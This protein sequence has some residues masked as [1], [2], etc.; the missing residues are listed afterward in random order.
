MD[1]TNSSKTEERLVE[2]IKEKLKR[3]MDQRLFKHSLGTMR[4][5]LGLLKRHFPMITSTYRESIEEK[6]LVLKISLSALL[7]D[8]AK[9]YSHEELL[10]MVK[11]N[12]WEIESFALR[13]RPILH[14]FVGDLMVE[15]DFDIHDRDILDP[16]KYHSTGRK[17]MGIIE[18]IIYISDK[19]EQTRDY[20]DIDLLREF[21][22]KDI[23]DCL[24]EVYKR[25][26]IYVLEKN[27]SLYPQTCGIW[28]YIC[29]GVD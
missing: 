2:E 26:I 4:Y 23:D 11:E 25:N 10:S 6:D 5:A 28:N 7:H 24:R 21:A 8:Y 29:G 19:I 14:S 18:K 22:D 15:R 16:I 3:A 9:T 12:R 1:Y 13:C 17:N 20:R 27:Q